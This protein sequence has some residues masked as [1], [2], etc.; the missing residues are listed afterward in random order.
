MCA[1]P[2]LREVNPT[3][4]PAKLFINAWVHQLEL[5]ATADTEA[6]ILD[7]YPLTIDISACQISYAIGTSPHRAGPWDLIG[8]YVWEFVLLF[9]CFSDLG[10]K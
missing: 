4:T 9:G 6:L 1:G 3:P 10:P 7:P 8:E 5:V 2:Y